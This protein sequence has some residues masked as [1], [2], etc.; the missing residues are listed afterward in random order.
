MNVL[1]PGARESLAEVIAKVLRKV[2]KE[3]EGKHEELDSTLVT[4]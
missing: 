2:A 4:Y 3:P 1:E